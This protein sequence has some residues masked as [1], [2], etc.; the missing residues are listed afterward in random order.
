[1]NYEGNEEVRKDLKELTEALYEV[2]RKAA[3]MESRYKWNKA[4][5]VER[6]TG[7]AAGQAKD[8]LAE[9]YRKLAEVE[10]QFQ[11]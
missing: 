4:G 6:L 10:H 11:D 8:E 5:L 9:T 1:M 7:T 2:Y 3:E